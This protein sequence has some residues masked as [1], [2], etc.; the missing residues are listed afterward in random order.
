MYYTQA[1][2]FEVLSPETACS[3]RLTYPVATY[4]IQPSCHGYIR[5]QCEKG[6]KLLSCQLDAY[7]SCEK[8]IDLL[9]YY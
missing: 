4:D 6:I 3:S 2:A 9:S 5:R 7:V 1:Q 8:G